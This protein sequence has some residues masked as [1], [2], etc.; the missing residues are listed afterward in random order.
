MSCVCVLVCMTVC[1]GG[2]REKLCC[3]GMLCW[4]VAMFGGVCCCCL[5]S[6]ESWSIWNCR[7]SICLLW[8]MA[9]S[10][11]DLTWLSASS[12][13]LW[14]SSLT[15]WR[16]LWCCMLKFCFINSVLILCFSSSS[17][18]NLFNSKVEGGCWGWFL[19]LLF[20]WLG[21]LCELSI[22]DPWWLKG[23]LLLVCVAC[24]DWIILFLDLTLLI[25]AVWSK[26]GEILGSALRS[27]TNLSPE[28]NPFDWGILIVVSIMGLREVLK[29]RVSLSTTILL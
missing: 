27:W 19:E 20:D 17:A 1:V 16:S 11:L 9:F 10:S 28:L 21:S 23:K 2:G 13:L 26:F 24:A 6:W 8:A 3:C 18:F 7:F 14:I 15:I 4:G 22:A 25:M 12:S 29:F 5:I